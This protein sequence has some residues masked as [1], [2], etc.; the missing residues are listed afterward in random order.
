MKNKKRQTA[1]SPEEEDFLVADL[2]FRRRK[3]VSEIAAELGIS[4]ESIYPTLQRLRDT[5]K[6]QYLP[7]LK[8]TTA[9]EL[10][11][12]YHLNRDTLTVVDLNDDPNGEHLAAVVANIALRVI[13]QVGQSRTGLVGLGLGPGRGT[14]EVARHLGN[15]MK[16]DPLTPQLRLITISSA[17]PAKFPE[18]SSTAFLNLFPSSAVEERIGLFTEPIVSADDFKSLQTRPGARDAFAA[19][20]DIDVVITSMGDQHEHDLLRTLM[21]QADEN[22]EA[23]DRKQWLGNVMYRPYSANGPILEEGNEQRAVTLFELDDFVR[24]SATRNKHVILLA[25]SCGLCGKSKATALR[26]L[27]ANNT[28]RVWSELVMDVKT[29]NELTSTSA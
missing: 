9:E 10:T 20:S 13:K 22:V 25:K 4:R 6:I 19:K 18:Y 28:L 29:A 15:L 7:P 16:S 23:L 26:P 11:K 12:R 17:C 24:M 1:Q 21:E 27:L 2:F 3:K 14:L 5:N 8:H